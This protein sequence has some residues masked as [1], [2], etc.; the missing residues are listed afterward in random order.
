MSKRR[1]NGARKLTMNAKQT[2][3]P[4]DDEMPA[5]IDF[6]KGTRGN[7]YGAG[8]RMVLPVHL[9]AELANALTHSAKQE[10]NRYQCL[11]GQTP[12]GTHRAAAK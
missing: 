8:A 1:S 12:R 7:F 11:R 6:S 3:Q 2:P 5:E 4:T 9:D 10:G